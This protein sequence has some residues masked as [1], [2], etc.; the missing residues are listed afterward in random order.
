MTKKD[1]N[2]DITKTLNKITVLTVIIIVLIL[3]CTP[4]FIY[5][6]SRYEIVKKNGNT[7]DDDKTADIF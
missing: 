7:L 1:K 4:F 6:K 5:F 2:K 3:L